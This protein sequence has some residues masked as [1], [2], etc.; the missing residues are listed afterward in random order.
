MLE[1]RSSIS[2]SGTV[3]RC[4]DTLLESTGT[5]I[6]DSRGGNFRRFTRKS[7]SSLIADR[8]FNFTELK[9]QVVSIQRRRVFDPRTVS[10]EE[11]NV[12]YDVI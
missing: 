8:T 11:A 4:Y 6:R 10:Q 5:F 12:P 7:R 2:S 3:Y 1:P 9:E